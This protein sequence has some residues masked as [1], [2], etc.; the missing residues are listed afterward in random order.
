MQVK[1]RKIKSTFDISIGQ[2]QEYE[3]LEN[4]TDEDIISIFYKIDKSLVPKLSVKDVNRIAQELR[5]ILGQDNTKHRLRLKYKGLGFEP[6]LENMQTGAFADAITYA[7]NIDTIHL[8]TSVMYRPLK[9]DI[10]YFLRS[11]KYNIQE[12]NGT[13]GI[14][15]QAKDLPLGLFLGAQAFFLTLR[16]DFLTA[17]RNRA[18]QKS[19]QSKAS[20]SNVGSTETGGG[21]YDFMQLLEETILKSRK[22]NESLYR[23]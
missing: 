22:S 6:D 9:K 10:Y 21:G 19:Q 5:E 17:I 3:K 12:Y 14:E 20:S 13:K 4:P 23:R 18:A 7:E 2:Y 15:Q 1:L 8:F 16:N 11:K